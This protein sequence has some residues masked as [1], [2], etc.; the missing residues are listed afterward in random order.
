MEREGEKNRRLHDSCLKFEAELAAYLDGED[1]SGLQEHAAGCDFCRCVLA[2]I[3]QIRALSSELELEGPPAVVWNRVR[4]ALIAEGIIRHHPGFWQRW[5]AGNR[6]GPLRMPVPVGA[7]IAAVAASVVLLKTPGYLLRTHSP[8]ARTVR[9]VAVPEYMAP[10]DLV[11]LKRTIQ[12]LQVAYQAN[13]SQLEPSM[14]ATYE[15]SLASLDDEIRE[16]ETSAQLEPENGLARQY[17]SAA[18]AQKAQVLQSALEFD[19]R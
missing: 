14:K 1:Q 13:E 5:V 4:S 7:L 18:Y 9:A 2:D 17:L 12:Q 6:L 3:E 8:A 11:Q 10:E 15:K 16:C 19:L